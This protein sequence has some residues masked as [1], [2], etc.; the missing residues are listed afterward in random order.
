M[1][2]ARLRR[3]A[4]ACL[5]CAAVAPATGFAATRQL[6]Y[7][8]LDAD[9]TLRDGLSVHRQGIPGSCD[10]ASNAVTDAFECLENVAS[11]DPLHPVEAI[12]VREPCYR[13]DRRASASVLCVL[14]PWVP[15]ATGFDVPA[16]PSPRPPV[17]R[18]WALELASG[19]GCVTIE[20]GLQEQPPIVAGRP[21]SFY[22]SPLPGGRSRSRIRTLFG[23]ANRRSSTWRIHAAL[24]DRGRGMRTVAVRVAWR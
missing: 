5:V 1:E 21:L 13:D 23:Q 3:W 6:V 8:P 9:G 11:T 2:I 20:I 19:L 17:R 12:D 7:H 22:C 4:A 15:T 10:R 18:P 24:D 16:L 14:S